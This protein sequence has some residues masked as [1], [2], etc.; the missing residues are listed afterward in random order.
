MEQPTFGGTHHM[1]IDIYNGVDSVV[2]PL[3]PRAIRLRVVAKK[4]LRHYGSPKEVVAGAFTFSLPGESSV[5]EIAD[6]TGRV[7][8]FR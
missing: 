7:K 5:Y 3:L 2:L 1:K 8:P 6:A 4:I